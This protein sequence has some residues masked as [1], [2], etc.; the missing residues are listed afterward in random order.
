MLLGWKQTTVE[1]EA[2]HETAGDGN[3]EV[4]YLSQGTRASHLIIKG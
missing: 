4:P 1:Q 3:T 2:W